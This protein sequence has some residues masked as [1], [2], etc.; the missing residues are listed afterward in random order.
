MKKWRLLSWNVNGIR[1][2]HRKDAMNWFFEQKPDVLCLQ[3]TKAHE[4]QIPDELRT[5]DGYHAFFSRPVRKGYSGVGLYSKTEPNKVVYGLGIEKFDAEGRT[6]IAYFDDFVLYNIY[7]PNGKAR[8][9]RLEYKMEFYDA[10]LKHAMKLKK[11]GL[12][13]VV[14]GDVNTAHKEIDLAHPKENSKVSGFLPEERAWIDKFI[15]KGFIDTFRM[16]NQEPQQYSWWDMR[17]FARDRNAGWRIDYFFI[18]ESLKGNITNAA[19]HQDIMGSDHCPI[20]I[21]LAF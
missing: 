12:N 21:E 8:T 10:F 1:A 16:F 11:K 5:I 14:C 4:E 20:S 3:E 15:G 2:V 6:L 17:T 19:I 9:E 13:I 18:S 7:Y